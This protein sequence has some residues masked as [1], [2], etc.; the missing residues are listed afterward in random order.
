MYFWHKKTLLFLCCIFFISPFFAAEQSPAFF[1]QSDAGVSGRKFG[2]YIYSSYDNH[3]VSYLEYNAILAQ[4]NVT[5]GCGIRNFEILANINA[6]LPVKC[7]DFYDYDYT[8]DGI[9]KNLCFFDNYA[10]GNAGGNICISYD[11]SFNDRFSFCPSFLFQYNYDSFIGKNGWGYFGTKDYSKNGQDVPWDSEF[12]RKATKVSRISYKTHNV[13]VFVGFDFK[14][15][16]S[17]K[18]NL[19]LGTYFSPFTKTYSIDYHFDDTGNNFDYELI[20][21]QSSSFKNFKERA[22]FDYYLNDT[23]GIILCGEWVSR[24]V[25]KGTIED[26][27]QPSGS[28]V[29]LAYVGIGIKKKF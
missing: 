29:S 21:I 17:S 16:L 7:G 9:T 18:M 22:Q 3:A 10:T 19:T 12:A 8:A 14:V 20:E 28:E 11:F 23:L 5:F 13:F 15:Y 6:A 27:Y 4:A 2:E 26:S 25:V 24:P 1:I